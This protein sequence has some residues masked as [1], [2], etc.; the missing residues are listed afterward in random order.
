MFMRAFV[1]VLAVLQPTSAAIVFSVEAPGIQQTSAAGVITETFDS[2]PLGPIGTYASPIGTYRGG[3][4][5]ASDA[6]GGA[7]QTEYAAIGVQ[8]GTASY[9][10]T[11][12][13]TRTY[14]GFYWS[15][16]DATNGVDFFSGGNVLQTFTIADIAPLL[17]A[18]H[19][20][21]PNTGEN[22]SEPYVFV[23]FVST[24]PASSF[25]RITFR[26]L[27]GGSGFESDNHT[28]GAASA[29]IPEPSTWV[30]ALTAFGVL[31]VYRRRYA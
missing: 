13:S 2:L 25:D 1:A 14:F 19:Y 23:N 3:A 24:N 11:F 26:N 12:T 17:S 5:V 16:G 7:N 20:A 18:A 4:V 10:L 8:S 29:P 28:I 9:D 15:A 31:S 30:L 27:S 21:N 22:E 6:F